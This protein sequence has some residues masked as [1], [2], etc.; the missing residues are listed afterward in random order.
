[1]TLHHSPDRFSASVLLHRFQLVTVA[2]NLCEHISALLRVQKPKGRLRPR[3]GQA[4][5]QP[6]ACDDMQEG[7]GLF[8]PS[9]P[10]DG[11]T[12]EPKMRRLL[13]SWQGPG[14]GLLWT[15]DQAERKVPFDKRSVRAG[16]SRV[17]PRSRR[18]KHRSCS[19]EMQGTSAE[20]V[21][22]K[23]AQMQL[24]RR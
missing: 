18:G 10:R 14:S 16:Q 8:R 3:D 11:E 9:G 13:R 7:V 24:F 4:P 5:G 12:R 19:S 20:L 2:L 17:T 23:M 22:R 6:F 21:P 1:M 15:G